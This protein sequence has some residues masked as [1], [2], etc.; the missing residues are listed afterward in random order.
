MDT[1]K[2]HLKDYITFTFYEGF[3]YITFSEIRILPDIQFFTNNVLGQ[4]I[5]C[6]CD[7]FGE[8]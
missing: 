2:L 1:K 3:Y 6:S 8:L 4:T 5:A 7:R